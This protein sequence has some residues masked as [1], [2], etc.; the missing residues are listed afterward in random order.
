[1]RNGVKI[2]IIVASIAMVVVLNIL[3]AKYT[4]NI[5]DNL[6]VKVDNLKE[7]LSEERFDKSKE[8]SKEIRK[9]WEKDTDKF[10]YF[11]DHEELEKLTLKIMIVDENLKNDDYD[12]A[13][14]DSIE[15]KFLLEHIKEKLKLKLSNV[16]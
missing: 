12:R 5:I 8:Q 13:I 15:V 4:D 16:F 11:M 10:G 7:S 14:E 2:A 1:M 6:G 3:I 9:I